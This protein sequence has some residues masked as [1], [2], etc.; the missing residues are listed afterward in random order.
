MN[1]GAIN[2]LKLPQ[3][4]LSGCSVVLTSYYSI[5]CLPLSIC[6]CMMVNA[7]AFINPRGLRVICVLAV[8]LEYGGLLQFLPD[9]QM[10]N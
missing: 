4:I 3:I 6:A 1:R 2:D 10:S 5:F 7:I 8:I 9:S